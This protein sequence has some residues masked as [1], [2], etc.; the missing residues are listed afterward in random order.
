MTFRN[1]RTNFSAVIPTGIIV[2]KKKI[3]LKQCIDF[4]ACN[5]L[6]HGLYQNWPALALPHE[7][8]LIQVMP[9]TRGVTLH[10]RASSLAWELMKF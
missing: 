8:A 5:A 6:G 3:K 9:T 2:K 4:H 7:P 1:A 10:I